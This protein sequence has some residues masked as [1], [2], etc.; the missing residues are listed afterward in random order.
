VGLKLAVATA[1][2]LGLTAALAS[3]FLL[4][5]Q[6]RQ[7]FERK[8]HSARRQA[9]QL[10]LVLEAP[11]EFDDELAIEE[12][13]RG[14]GDDPD[15]VA[16]TIVDRDRPEATTRVGTDIDA[17]EFA[18]DPPAV[19][20][21]PDTMWIAWSIGKGAE[22]QGTLVF[23]LSLE[24]ETATYQRQRDLILAGCGSLALLVAGLLIFATRRMVVLPLARLTDAAD[25]FARGEPVAVPPIGSDEVGRLTQ[26]FASMMDAIR[27]RE[28]KLADAHAE[29][30]GLLDAMRH[31]VFGFG[32]D[33]K[34][35]G[36]SSRAAEQLFAR[37]DITGADV[38]ELLLAGQPEGSLEAEALVAF[39]EMVFELPPDAWDQA[40]ELAPRELRPYAGLP[41]ERVLA[42]EFVPLHDGVSL[43]RVLV[44]VSDETEHRRIAAEMS[45]LRDR[46]AAELEATRRLLGMGAGM[47]VEFASTTE[48]RMQSVHDL[49]GDPTP[50]RIDEV[51]RQV[52]AARGDARGLGLVDLT[53]TLTAAEAVLADVRDSVDPPPHA[54][55]S[56]AL[57]EHL[58]KVA[59]DLA[60]ERERLIAAS[61]LGEAVLDQVAVSM[62]DLDE[63]GVLADR[64]DPDL[65]RCIQRVRGRWFGALLVGVE[66]AAHSWASMDGKRV[67]VEIVGG[68]TRVDAV[69]GPA[70][71]TAI[72]QMVRNAIAHGIETPDVRNAAGK[73]PSGSICIAAETIDESV[74]V[75]VRDDGRGLDLEDL[76]ARANDLGVEVETSELPFV[77]G[78][79]TRRNADTLAGRGVGLAAARDALTRCGYT[80]DVASEPRTS[81]TF[82]IRRTNAQLAARCA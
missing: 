56:V 38:R 41:E 73:P 55:W 68:Q 40:V 59:I 26:T 46:H 49:V 67:R 32:P 58:D 27:E 25:A 16:L 45:A 17:P 22:V 2:I 50:A 9:E 8:E 71:R 54:R 66:D 60:R 51:M 69:L 37:G 72:V 31:A 36:R 75:S 76:R 21:E 80:I 64:A 18:S 35:I 82:R 74:V 4:D 42:L 44:V 30:G 57:K 52:H 20:W 63:L 77:S 7:V 23:G 28:S 78:L 3:Y 43:Q 15:L 33:L 12:A 34:V 10:A 81:T 62:R 13:L 65:R 61:P 19:S 5:H 24:N 79:S 48:A 53:R 14:I 11:L 70:L 6:R 29:V 47:F 39:L 1:V